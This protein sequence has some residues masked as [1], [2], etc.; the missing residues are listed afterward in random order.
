M[1]AVSVQ[2]KSPGTWMC[3]A[4]PGQYAQA[5][6][7]GDSMFFHAADWD[8]AI[9]IAINQHWRCAVLDFLMPA[10]SDSFFL[11]IM[12]VLGLIFVARKQNACL[13][14]A[15]AL[16]LGIGAADLTCSLIKE[17]TQRARPYKSVPKTWYRDDGHWMQRPDTL[18]AA[19]SGSSYPSAHAANAA[20]AVWI[21]CAVQ[22]MRWAWVV[23]I[24][25][26]YSRVYLGKHFPV[27]VMAGWATGLAVALVFLPCYELAANFA[28][29]RWMRYRLRT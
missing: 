21:L 20:A 12:S 17:N 5:F 1:P 16:G 9:Q 10:L 6:N 24:M 3:P 7:K 28:R 4:L 18:P 13:A 19:A 22:R 8:Q 23:P 29:S 27:D 25:I 26:G 2:P 15:L 14:L 11:W